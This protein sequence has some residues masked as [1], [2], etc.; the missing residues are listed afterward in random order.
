MGF[1]RVG[2]VV[3]VEA[4]EVADEEVLAAEGEVRVREVE[5]APARRRRGLGVG[6]RVGLGVGLDLGLD[7]RFGVRLG[8]DFGLGGFAGRHLRVEEPWRLGKAGDELQVARGLPGVLQ[9]WL[10]PDAR[11]GRS[12]SRRLLLR[13]DP[14]PQEDRDPDCT[15][16]PGH[17]RLH[18]SGSFATIIPRMRSIS[19]R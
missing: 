2:E 15:Y 9:P 17:N 13:A 5:A 18:F 4:V 19:I 16:H 6:F 10:E 11:V 3:D 8:F 1:R 14:C 7:V 12:G